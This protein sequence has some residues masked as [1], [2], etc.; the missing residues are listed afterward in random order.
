MSDSNK[1]SSVPNHLLIR[2]RQVHPLDF[3][4]DLHLDSQ[5]RSRM[6]GLSFS[7]HATPS[8]FTRSTSRSPGSRLHPREERIRH[9]L[10]LAYPAAP[11]SPCTCNS[12]EGRVAETARKDRTRGRTEGIRGS[13]TEGLL[14]SRRRSK[15]DFRDKSNAPGELP[16]A[17][18]PPNRARC[19]GNARLQPQ[20]QLPIAVL[21]AEGN[22]HRA[23]GALA[24]NQRG[25]MHNSNARIECKSEISKILRSDLMPIYGRNIGCMCEVSRSKYNSYVPTPW[26]VR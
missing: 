24:R 1:G 23:E 15:R 7:R 10:S 9:A 19:A 2:L 13:H 4:Q 8:S 20:G 18:T 5:T 17:P 12:L 3:E 14:P 26:Y 6:C 25:L 22:P 21:S 16:R 11:A